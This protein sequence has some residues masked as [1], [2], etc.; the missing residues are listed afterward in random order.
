MKEI[1]VFTTILA[2]FVAALTL[3]MYFSGRLVS[4]LFP[5]NLTEIAYILLML[6]M[7]FLLVGGGC[8]TYSEKL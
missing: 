2:A 1:F 8:L 3:F 5:E 6:S 7:L 4:K